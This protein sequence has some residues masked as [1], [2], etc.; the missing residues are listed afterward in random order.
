MN[1]PASDDLGAIIESAMASPDRLPEVMRA[2]R[3]STLFVP[4]GPAY[5][6]GRGTF[7]PILFDRNG[8]TYMVVFTSQDKVESVTP[9]AIYT[10]VMRG[11]DVFKSVRGGLGVVVNPGYRNGLEFDPDAVRRFA[12]D[13]AKA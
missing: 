4:S 3:S 5:G 8:V 7:Q 11:Q 10:A 1:L 2:M 6:D 12:D 9:P 13:E